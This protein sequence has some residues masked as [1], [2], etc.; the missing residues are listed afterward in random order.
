MKPIGRITSLLALV[1]LAQ[2]CSTDTG[3]VG[4]GAAA[5]TVTVSFGD[6]T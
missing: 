2:A 6:V 3:L 5:L 4:P 1:V